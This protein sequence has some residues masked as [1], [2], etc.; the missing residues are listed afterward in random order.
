MM[1]TAALIIYVTQTL[2]LILLGFKHTVFGAQASHWFTL[3]CLCYCFA[4]DTHLYT[5]VGSIYHLVPYIIVLS[6][7]K[8]HK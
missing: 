3:L 8:A 2:V 7:L 4:D 5:S 6:D 1:I